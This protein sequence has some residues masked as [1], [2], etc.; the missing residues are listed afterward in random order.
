M[1]FGLKKRGQRL[2]QKVRPAKTGLGCNAQRHESDKDSDAK[3]S[4]KINFEVAEIHAAHNTQRYGFGEIPL[5]AMLMLNL[6]ARIV[7][8]SFGA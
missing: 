3:Q 4:K 1:A 2:T 8:Y 7:G 6:I 5:W